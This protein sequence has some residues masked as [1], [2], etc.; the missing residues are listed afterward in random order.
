MANPD[1][2]RPTAMEAVIERNSSIFKKAQGS[3]LGWVYG[4]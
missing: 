4:T 2:E 3:F 1:R